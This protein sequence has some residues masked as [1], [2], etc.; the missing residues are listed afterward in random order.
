VK[1][2]EREILHFLF[3]PSAEI[4]ARIAEPYRV[5]L[6]QYSRSLGDLNET[7]KQTYVKLTQRQ[8]HKAMKDDALLVQMS[9][10]CFWIAGK[11]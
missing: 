9:H 3:A 4:T 11:E 8:S 6:R 1:N 7:E 5:G 2:E 10:A